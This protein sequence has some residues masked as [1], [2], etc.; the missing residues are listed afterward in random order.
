LP[1]G[2]RLLPPFDEPDETEGLD[3]T[4]TALP[5]V[6]LPPEMASLVPEIACKS[7]A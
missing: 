7:A 5:V 6:D 4:V 2:A 1:G 3:E